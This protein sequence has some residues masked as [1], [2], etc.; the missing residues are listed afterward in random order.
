MLR[1]SDCGTVRYGYVLTNAFVS[2]IGPGMLQFKHLLE[3][4]GACEKSVR[5]VRH[6]SA[7]KNDKL[8]ETGARSQQA[9]QWRRFAR[10]AKL[11]Q[12]RPH[13]AQDFCAKHS[14]AAPAPR[15]KHLLLY[16]K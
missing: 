11:R 8:Q 10:Q 9:R 2:R 6:R 12:H 13:I 3:G 15:L 4:F 5:V 7:N 16:L 1:L 14:A